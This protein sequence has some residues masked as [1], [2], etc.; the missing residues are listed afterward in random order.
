MGKRRDTGIVKAAEI[1][2][3]VEIVVT[4]WNNDTIIYHKRIKVRWLMSN[5]TKEELLKA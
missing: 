3:R 5:K 4:L 2:G 1:D